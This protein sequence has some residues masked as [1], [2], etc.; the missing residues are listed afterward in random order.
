MYWGHGATQG[1]LPSNFYLKIQNFYDLMDS[2][3]FRP[4]SDSRMTAFWIL[5]G[6]KIWLQRNE[7]GCLADTEQLND[8]CLMNSTQQWTMIVA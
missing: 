4:Q 3:V 8:D 6:N 1:C 2:A 5:P 7:L